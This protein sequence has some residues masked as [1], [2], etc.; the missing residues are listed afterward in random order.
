LL[1]SHGVPVGAWLKSELKVN[2]A[3]RVP[4]DLLKIPTDVL[5]A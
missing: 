3:A 5:T 1:L 4:V 2:P